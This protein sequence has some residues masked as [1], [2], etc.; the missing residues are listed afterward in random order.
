M[1]RFF[2]SLASVCG[3]AVLATVSILGCPLQAVL[4]V[5]TWPFDKNRVVTGYTYRLMGVT[6]ATFHPL[7]RF[8]LHKKVRKPSV[9]MVVVSNHNSNA[10]TFL[11]S[12]LPWE[13]KWLGK[14]SLFKV[15]IMGW[16][17][18]MNGDIP[19]VRGDKESAIKAM[20][21]C[22]EYLRNGMSVMIFPEGTRSK[23]EDLLPFKNGA[24]RLAIDTQAPILPLAVSGT[25]IALGKHDWRF[26]Y[27]KALC[28]AGEP[29][30][31]EGLTLDDL[32][33]LKARVRA[34]IEALRAEIK[35]LTSV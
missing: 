30:P 6:A 5:F 33:D 31:T 29:I 11:I 8:R 23:T 9:P 32:E 35:P 22:A 17:M 13:M 7:W 28:N 21:R 20:G 1:N 25:R 14:A 27:S 24:F 19:V 18:Q 34:A 4:A 3:W 2:V 15:P 26:G 12:H 16:S 10:D